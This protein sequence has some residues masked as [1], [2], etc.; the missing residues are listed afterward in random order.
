MLAVGQNVTANEDHDDDSTS[1]VLQHRGL[2]FVRGA[3]VIELRC[4]SDRV[5]DHVNGS[6]SSSFDIVPEARTV[7]APFITRCCNNTTSM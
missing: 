4:A 3:E 5:N 1:S 2:N 7:N 6:V